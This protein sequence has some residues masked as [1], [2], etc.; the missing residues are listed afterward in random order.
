MVKKF[1]FSN[2][3]EYRHSA[4]IL[5]YVVFGYLLVVVPVSKRL[6]VTL[7]AVISSVALV[8]VGLV[9]FTNLF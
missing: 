5:N 4:K 9:S 7:H 3:P 1:D 2:G 6:N 8:L